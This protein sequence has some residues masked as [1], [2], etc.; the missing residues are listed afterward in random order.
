[1]HTCLNTKSPTTILP[2]NYQHRSVLWWLCC[3][4]SQVHEESKERPGLS[5][6][7]LTWILRWDFISHFP[8][9]L[10]SF[11]SLSGQRAQS[12]GPAY[13]YILITGITGRYHHAP[14]LKVGSG[15]QSQVLMLEHQTLHGPSPLPSLRFP[16]F[17]KHLVAW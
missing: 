2:H 4:F 12:Q 14:F 10:I 1:M 7:L 13:L 9:D 11:S 5:P 8:K 17:W 6:A 15:T 16:I 3:V